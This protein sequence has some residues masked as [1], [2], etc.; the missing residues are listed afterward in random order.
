LTEEEKKNREDLKAKR[1][2]EKL[3]KAEEEKKA[4]DA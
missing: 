1:E 2:A 4:L 3:A